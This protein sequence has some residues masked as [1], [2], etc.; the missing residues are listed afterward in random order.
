MNW[1]S[2]PEDKPEEYV[3]QMIDLQFD[4]TGAYISPPP[5]PGDSVTPY[6]VKSLTGF[7]PAQ[8]PP[9]QASVCVQRSPSSQGPVLFV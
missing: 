9:L 1:A 5:N 4:L 7:D 8:N 3:P 2:W 6:Q